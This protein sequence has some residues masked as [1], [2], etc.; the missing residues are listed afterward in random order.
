MLHKEYSLLTDD[1]LLGV[2]LR[3]CRARNGDKTSSAYLFL[4]DCL[5]VKLVFLSSLTVLCYLQ[6]IHKQAASPTSPSSS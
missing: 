6:V 4:D 3:S 2:L 5:L 1:T